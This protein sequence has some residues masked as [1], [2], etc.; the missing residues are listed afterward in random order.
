MDYATGIAT[1]LVIE[2]DGTSY[3]IELAIGPSETLG[4]LEDVC[5]R[6]AEAYCLSAAAEAY[7]LGKMRFCLFDPWQM[8]IAFDEDDEGVPDPNDAMDN[9]F[10]FL[11]LA[12]ADED[13]YSLSDP[14]L[15]V[16]PCNRQQIDIWEE[17]MALGGEYHQQTICLDEQLRE[18]FYAETEAQFQNA[19]VQ[20]C[21]QKS[22]RFLFRVIN[23]R[24]LAFG[25]RSL[26]ESI[27]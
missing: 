25:H 17:L 23:S 1:T 11:F 19:K 16:R 7:T 21:P 12:S 14:W 6:F 13:E 22:Y 4:D 9:R 8:I 26:F 15:V 27:F 20:S 24:R 10:S 2:A 3:E 18:R 5:H